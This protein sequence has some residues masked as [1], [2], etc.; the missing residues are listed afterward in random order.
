MHIPGLVKFEPKQQITGEHFLE[1]ANVLMT[2]IDSKFKQLAP[3]QD[4]KPKKDVILSDL[5]IKGI[6]T[7]KEALKYSG[8]T[9]AELTEALEAKQVLGKSTE[10]TIKLKGQDVISHT[11]K[12]N[13]Q[14]LDKFLENYGSV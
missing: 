14:S 2:G 12:I 1:F 6:L 8:L 7:M 13:R 10:R 11:W 3:A 9:K 5:K 4:S